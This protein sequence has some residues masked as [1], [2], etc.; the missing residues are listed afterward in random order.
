[1]RR[2]LLSLS[3]AAALAACGDGPEDQ[4]Q[5]NSAEELA[6]RIEHLSELRPEVPPPRLAFLKERDLGPELRTRPACR[7]H[8]ERKLI[9]VVNASGAVA[10][11][12]GRRVA[13]AVSGPVGPT[14]GFFT[15]PGVTFS[16]GRTAPV[17]EAAE[18]YGEGWPAQATVGGMKDRDPEKIEATW[19]CS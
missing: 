7:L 18:G 15:A 9:L 17:V 4:A 1:M 12:D 11:V 5:A 6:N 19:I 13:L 2:A 8:R 16:V 3:L 14:G 10:R